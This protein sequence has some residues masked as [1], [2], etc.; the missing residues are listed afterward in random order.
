ME[1]GKLSLTN[2]IMTK[3]EISAFRKK[4]YWRGFAVASI[5]W[6]GSLV[7]IVNILIELLK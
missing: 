5:A 6:L 2:K 7:I 1:A 4:H 3:E